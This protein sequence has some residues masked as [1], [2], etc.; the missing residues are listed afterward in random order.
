[1]S[2]RELAISCDI[3]YA[4][5][6]NNIE[7]PKTIKAINLK[8][9]SAYLEITME[10]VFS[11]MLDKGES[12]LKILLDQKGSKLAGSIYH[13]TQIRFAYN[14]NRIEGSRLTEDE[15]RYIF[16]TNTLI[17]GKGSN[18]VDD[19]VE[20]ANHFYLFDVMLEEAAELLSEKM[21]KKYHGLLKNGTTDARKNWFNVGDY[22]Q[23]PNEVGGKE[24][25][26]PKDV[27]I[28]IRKLLCWY[29]GISEITL[30]EIIDFHY[31]FEC[32]HP[33]QDG[34]GRVGRL[35]MFKE[36]LRNNIMPYIIEDNYKA[37]YYRGLSEFGNEKG[38]LRDT[39][40]SM[41]D[42]YRDTVNRL[43]PE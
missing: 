25:T 32:I 15:T 30:E 26:N 19:V 24:T 9:I 17:D 28:A 13:F 36:C 40:L 43:L 1:M 21:I 23:L 11:M 42:H 14:T 12:L 27:A 34:N 7:K 39:C 41:Q 31:R 20:T 5:L 3:P 10:E 33:F 8:K 38:W 18:N 16:E 4:T 22:K 29:N 35:I 6:Y 2:L 37:F